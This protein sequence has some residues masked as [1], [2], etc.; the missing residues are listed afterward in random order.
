MDL[1][2]PIGIMA[3]TA[4]RCACLVPVEPYPMYCGLPVAKGNKLRMCK[5]HAQAYL[6]T[7]ANLR[8]IA[9]DEKPIGSGPVYLR[10]AKK[11]KAA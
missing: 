1:P 10:E 8:K 7:T 6:T 11:D 3:L 4:G 9:K 5:H 2:K